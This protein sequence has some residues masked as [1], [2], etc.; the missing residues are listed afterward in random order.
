MIKRIIIIL[1]FSYAGM[2]AQTNVATN[3]NNV[4]TYAAYM[5]TIR[6][7]IP[8]MKLNAVSETNAMNAL[9]SAESSGDVNLN[10]QAGAVG[11][12][13]AFSSSSL[14]NGSPSVKANG[15]RAGIGLGSTVP[16]SGTRWSVNLT[17][18]AF[19]G[20]DVYYNGD[21][22]TSTK[23]KTYGPSVTIEVSQPIL[24]N[25]FGKLDMYPIKDAEYALTIAKL[26][27]RVDDASVLVSY[28]KMYYQWIMLEKLLSY[29]QGMINNAKAFQNQMYRR[30]Q[31]DLIDNDAY[32]NARRQT[33]QYQDFYTKSKVDLE[34]LLSSINFFIMATN[35]KPDH[36]V[37]DAYLQLAN[38]ISI[39]VIPFSDS[40]NGEM[41]YQAKIRAE[42]A[43]ES[44]KNNSLP[45]LSIVGSVSLNNSTPDTS[46]Y[47]RSFGNM[48]NVD[49]F[50]GLQFS[51]PLGGRAA[52]ADLENAKNALYGIM[53]DYERLNRDFDVQINA[54]SHQFEGYKTLIAS[55]KAQINAINSRISTQLVKLDQGR[56]EVDDL[57]TARLELVAARTELL[58]LQY[59]YISTIFDYRA[60][61]AIE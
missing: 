4:I 12:Y 35:I 5:E 48:T 17:H 52:K 26:Q 33:L 6:D 36:N 9:L 46:G 3:T 18:N 60:L 51:Y 54:Y 50:A 38:S 15:L 19:L 55:K 61:L 42:Y 1:L 11:K 27:R 16:Y 23:F 24:R 47:F 56:L 53:S 31:N 21:N 41:A 2:F 45:D 57:I 43:L 37:W 7:L 44:M 34:N 29:Y 13:G 40:V 10:L 28:Q 32:Q 25:F 58:N 14:G 49:Y 22:P 30:L 59:E 20:G 39:K 8:E